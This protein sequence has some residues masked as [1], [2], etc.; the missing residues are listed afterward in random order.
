MDEKTIRFRYQ[1]ASAKLERIESNLYS[2]RNVWAQKKGCG[3]GIGVLREVVHFADEHDIALVLV[4]QPYGRG[5]L[6][7][8][9]LFD[10]YTRMG[11]Q[12]LAGTRTLQHMIRR[13]SYLRGKADAKKPS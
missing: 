12:K 5:G 11:F 13:P 1:S 8:D 2:L 6:N 4:A 3:H 7:H 9:Q 10:L